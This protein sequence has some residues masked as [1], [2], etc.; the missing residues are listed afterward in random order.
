MKSEIWG[1]YGKTISEQVC[2]DLFDSAIMKPLQCKVR[3][4][5]WF[6][7]NPIMVW[8]QTKWCQWKL[9]CLLKP[10]V[11]QT[12]VSK[13]KHVI[14]TSIFSD[15]GSCGIPQNWIKIPLPLPVKDF[16]WHLKLT[17][18]V[19]SIFPNWVKI[20]LPNTD[21]SSVKMV[22]VSLVKNLAQSNNLLYLYISAICGDEME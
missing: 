18:K 17:V 3:M 12:S 20:P 8:K 19:N 5:K 14:L 11:K 16:E 22:T 7:W 4:V 21:I 2:K 10:K 1:Y 6:Q 13:Q 15:K 9:F